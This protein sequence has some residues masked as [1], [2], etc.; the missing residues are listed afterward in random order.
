MIVVA[1]LYDLIIYPLHTDLRKF[2]E[3]IS[4]ELENIFNTTCAFTGLHTV[5]IDHMT[6]MV[7]VV[8]EMKEKARLLCTAPE[9]KM[10]SP[11]SEYHY[12]F[13]VMNLVTDTSMLS[14][15]YCQAP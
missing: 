11:E 15:C 10:P 13:S 1:T 3:R 12:I 4:A 14:L 6:T 7:G 8:T 2:L 5:I 9:Q